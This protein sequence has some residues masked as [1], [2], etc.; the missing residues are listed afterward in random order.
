MF[1]NIWI[2]DVKLI[3]LIDTGA[4]V[5]IMKKHVLTKVKPNYYKKEKS[6]SI[7]GIGSVLD[8]DG[9]VNVNIKIGDDIFE[10]TE[11]HIVNSDV[12][13]PD[14][15]IGMNVINKADI[16]FN[17]F[18]MKIMKRK[19]DEIKTDFSSE[20]DEDSKFAF[21]ID[22][23]TNM[24]ERLVQNVVISDKRIS[25]EVKEEILR[26]KPNKIDNTE[27]KMKIVVTDDIPV[28]QT[29]RRLPLTEYNLVN[30]QVEKWMK[31]GIIQHSTSE[32]A[33]PIVLVSKKDGT[34]RLCV[35]Y[36]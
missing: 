7:S 14:L 36:R 20:A 8:T 6:I 28:H 33:S 5:T 26:Y 16:I 30:E 32:Y 9:T 2:N 25:D 22:V 10:E 31:E 1:H 13:I 24:Q 19:D 27:I 18:G 11:V 17:K 12:M 15:V 23:V 21:K 4:D 29:P 3:A 34:K 35:D